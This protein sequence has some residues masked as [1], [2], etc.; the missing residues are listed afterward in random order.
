MLSIN[1][2][3]DPRP[4]AWS[5]ASL[6]TSSYFQNCL[7]IWRY[8]GLSGAESSDQLLEEPRGSVSWTDE[9]LQNHL[10]AGRLIMITPTA[11]VSNGAFYRYR[12]IP[13][14]L[15][16]VLADMLICTSW[17]VAT[18]LISFDKVIFGTLHSVLIR[19]CPPHFSGCITDRGNHLVHYVVSLLE[20]YPPHF[21]GCI[22]DRRN[23][24][25]H[26]V[27]VYFSWHRLIGRFSDGEFFQVFNLKM[28]W[29]IILYECLAHDVFLNQVKNFCLMWW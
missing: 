2:S 11:R 21:S 16:N 18:I 24:L 9:A 14:V 29:N 22:T 3:N 4:P 7:C 23:H 26:Y 10:S 19:G 12:S 13:I 28:L 17:Y 6:C 5:L 25:V 1:R 27:E 20:G 15:K 8:G